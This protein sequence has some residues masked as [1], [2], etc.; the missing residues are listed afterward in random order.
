VQIRIQE[1][2]IRCFFKKRNTKK[3]GSI[4]FLDRK[5]NI[6]VNVVY[7]GGG[8]GLSVEGGGGG[9]GKSNLFVVIYFNILLTYPHHIALFVILQGLL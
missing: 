2:S 5:K 6:E 8:A 9:E 7:K 3:R 1:G 4:D